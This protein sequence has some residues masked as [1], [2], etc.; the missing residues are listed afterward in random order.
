[1]KWFIGRC[2]HFN[3]NTNI[4]ILFDFMKI[5]C[6]KISTGNTLVDSV[7][8]QEVLLQYLVCPYTEL[9]PSFDFTR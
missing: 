5:Y 7:A 1:M 6:I 8:L 2:H 3:S 9:S 4:E